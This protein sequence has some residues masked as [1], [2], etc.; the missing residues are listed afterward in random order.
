MSRSFLLIVALTEL[1]GLT[2]LRAAQTCTL[3]VQVVDE[4]A[5]PA[6]NVPVHVTVGQDTRVNAAG[7]QGTA[8]FSSLPCGEASIEVGQAS[9]EWGPAWAGTTRTL[10]PGVPATARLVI[11][12]RTELTIR[13]MDKRG[14]PVLSGV[15]QGNSS[16]ASGRFG[17]PAEGGIV[18]AW[19]QP[20][21]WS[22]YWACEQP[23]FVPGPWI[24]QF[25]GRVNADV[26]RD[27][28]S[29]DLVIQT[30]IHL[31]GSVLDSAGRAIAG[32]QVS[33]RREGTFVGAANTLPDGRFTLELSTLPVILEPFAHDRAVAFDPPSLTVQEAPTE[34]LVFVAG[35]STRPV[36]HGKVV[37]KDSG[38]G[39]PG[40]SVFVRFNCGD[41][42]PEG[43]SYADIAH[44]SLKTDQDGTFEA[45][46]ATECP[47]Q[48]HASD[49]SR[50]RASL[51]LPAGSCE[52]QIVLQLEDRP[53]WVLEGT[54]ADRKGAPVEGLPLGL[55]HYFQPENGDP[56]WIPSPDVRA[57][58]G[59]DGTFRIEREGSGRFRLEIDRQGTAKALRDLVLVSKRTPGA[60]FEVELQPKDEK[61]VEVRALPG[62][63]L[64]VRAVNP[65]QAPTKLSSITLFPEE[66]DI[67][68]QR[69]NPEAHYLG[70][71]ARY[72]DKEEDRRCLEGIVPGRYRVLLDE[73]AQTIPV[74]YPSSEDRAGAVPVAITSGMN[75]LGPVVLREVG[76]LLLTVDSWSG[77]EPPHIELRE[78]TS[79]SP[80][81]D[82]APQRWTGLAANRM[83]RREG[84]G[85]IVY[86]IPAG[87]WD[88]R[89]CSDPECAKTDGIWSAAGPIEIRQGPMLPVHLGKPEAISLLGVPLFPLQFPPPVRGRLEADLRQAREAWERSPDDPEAL[90]WLG[91]RTAF[92]GKYGEAVEIFSRGTARWPD[93]PRFLRH[94]GHRLINLRRL[95]DAIADL[96]RAAQLMKKWPEE[97][98]PDGRPNPTGPPTLT[99]HTAVW[100]HLGVAHFA[101]GDFEQARQAFV[102]YMAAARNDDAIVMGTDWLYMSL[103]R[104]GQ[105]AEA[106]KV[107]A[108]VRTDVALTDG[109]DALDRLLLYR[110]ERTPRRLLETENPAQ[111]MA[112]GFGV[113]HWYLLAGRTAEAEAAFRSVLASGFWGPL[114]NVAAEAELA[115]LG[116]AKP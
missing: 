76:G 30:P 42:I 79:E 13:V 58:T 37:R 25:G 108:Q 41:G 54:I 19:V 59:E 75:E 61:H 72:G 70:N 60:R 27:P 81:V 94:R 103:R 56:V 12:A 8:E 62:A 82:P 102:A 43:L 100:L 80:A 107:L 49:A 29:V 92:L 57:R 14:H 86:R 74:W 35:P 90:L 38:V 32:A 2:E 113:G 55:S 91:R 24:T 73:R 3:V 67:A 114:A 101:K 1:V 63:T 110:G 18:K 89:A 44:L 83:E 40:A 111:K 15:V 116:R 16:L 48:V 87:R 66:E 106:A 10:S 109:A 22:F 51:E 65:A 28:Q 52:R 68:V 17:V 85:F 46:C 50:A 20:G 5:K 23:G 95:D 77:A 98:E 7:P 6:A 33:A 115:R 104:L 105:E 36:L 64:C 88:I 26:G 96:R 4:A 97:S 21:S 71:A 47:L 31:E 34:P 53:S 112:N 9:L 84:G 69:T 39:A 11:V 78:W 45:R 93:D 99:L